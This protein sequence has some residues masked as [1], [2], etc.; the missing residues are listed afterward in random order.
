MGRGPFFLQSSREEPRVRARDGNEDQIPDSPR[1][2]PL[3]G[4]KN[5]VI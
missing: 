1:E 4:D 5:G 2:I 3:L